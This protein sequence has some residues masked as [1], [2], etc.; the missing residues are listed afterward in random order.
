ME[1][2]MEFPQTLDYLKHASRTGTKITRSGW[3]GSA[4][5]VCHQAGYPDGVTINKN[6]S[7]ATGL[8]ERIRGAVP[9]LSHVQNGSGRFV[10]WVASQTDLLENDWKIFA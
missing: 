10:P 3:N 6:T 7:D 1:T 5:F 8:P 4:M 2:S 9:S